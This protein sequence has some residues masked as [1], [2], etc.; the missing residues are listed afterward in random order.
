MHQAARPAL[1]SRILKD[2]RAVV[3][4]FLE[5]QSFAAFVVHG[6]IRTPG[7]ACQCFLRA[8]ENVGGM[9]IEYGDSRLISCTTWSRRKNMHAI[10][11]SS[12]S[13]LG[14]KDSSRTQMLCAA[15][16]YHLPRMIVRNETSG[17]HHE[18]KRASSRRYCH[19]T[20]V[21]TPSSRALLQQQGPPH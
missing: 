7:P 14:E 11:G 4:S 3:R 13:V 16:L 2:H 1:V 21:I 18:A 8:H 12:T 17:W 5:L 6:N 15:S 9:P 20:P 10:C 19:R